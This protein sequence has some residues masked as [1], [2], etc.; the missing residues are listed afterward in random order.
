MALFEWIGLDMPDDPTSLAPTTCILST[1]VPALPLISTT[2]KCENLVLLLTKYVV[3]I[4]VH[5]GA[6]QLNDFTS[7]AKT[8][9]ENSTNLHMIWGAKSA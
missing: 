9:R 8:Q 4:Q 7:A 1:V 6:A 2:P 5:R 3:C